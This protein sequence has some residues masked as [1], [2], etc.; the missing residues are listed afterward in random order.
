MKLKANGDIIAEDEKCLLAGDIFQ[1]LSGRTTTPYPKQK[2]IKYFTQ[3]LID[4]VIEEAKS[5]GDDFNALIFS[6][7]KPNKYGELPPASVQ[8]MVMYLFVEQPEVKRRILKPLI[9]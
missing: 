7:E 3:W 9:G 4:N 2:R 8:S 6:V 5:R 1:T